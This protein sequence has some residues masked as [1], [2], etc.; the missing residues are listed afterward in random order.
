MTLTVNYYCLKTISQD[1]SLYTAT[2]AVKSFLLIF[3][4]L[5]FPNIRL[6]ELLK[7]SWY[8]PF[9]PVPTVPA[10]RTVFCGFWS[11]Q[12]Q[13]SFLSVTRFFLTWTLLCRFS[14]ECTLKFPSELIN[15]SVEV[16]VYCN[17]SNFTWILGKLENKRKMKAC[18]FGCIYF[19]AVVRVSVVGK[20]DIAKLNHF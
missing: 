12:Q 6:V 4:L 18:F 11:V 1:L 8:Y 9:S 14:S 3:Y 5:P 16:F 13:Q 20:S 15:C 10:C 17:C 2:A 19:V 7:R